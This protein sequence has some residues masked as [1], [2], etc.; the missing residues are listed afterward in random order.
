[1]CVATDPACRSFDTNLKKELLKNGLQDSITYIDLQ[2]VANKENYINSIFANYGMSSNINN[3][4]LFLAFENGKI[5]SYLGEGE[6]TKLTVEETI[7]FIK[8]YR[9]GI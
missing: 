8:K 1:M 3:T 4:P 9:V 7:K 6:A 2:G 5:A